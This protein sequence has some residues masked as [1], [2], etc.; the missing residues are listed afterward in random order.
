MKHQYELVALR[1]SVL[2]LLTALAV[3]LPFSAAHADSSVW[4]VKSDSSTLYIGGTVHLL[5]PSD[6]PLPSEYEEAYGDSQELYFE[7]DISSMNDLSVQAKM[8]Q[9][10]TY[11][12]DRTLNSVLNDEAY[13]ALTEYT[14][15]V[16]LPLMMM[17]KFKPG[18]I[19]S[20]LQI[21]E[22]QKLGFTPQGVD[23][24]FNARGIGDGKS[25]GALET[26][27]EQI[28][29]LAA[30]GEGNESEFIL[31]SLSDLEK[32]NEIMGEMI[33]AWRDGDSDRLEEL[34]VTDMKEQAPDLYDSLLRQRNFRWI[35]QIEQM[36]NDSDTEFVLVGAAHLI[37]EDGLVTLLRARGYEVTQL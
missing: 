25:I 22:F 28:G 18:M 7:T 36:L 16:G 14:E 5:R 12:D 30:M 34:F 24:H 21:L 33:T 37:G 17:E 8:L 3:V 10:L 9:E 19:V 1:N 32:T 13:T 15:K 31:L 2:T 6:Y 27:E 4:Q 23:A 35:P 29:F 11:N 26:I 20:T